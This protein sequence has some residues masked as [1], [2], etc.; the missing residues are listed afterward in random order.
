MTG[1]HISN[2]QLNLDVNNADG[3]VDGQEIPAQLTPFDPDST[4]WKEVREETYTYYNPNPNAPKVVAPD[5]EDVD[6]S[7][8]L[9]DDDYCAD[10]DN[11]QNEEQKEANPSV[12]E[13]RQHYEDNCLHTERIRLAKQTQQLYNKKV[14]PYTENQRCYKKRM[15]S[16]HFEVH[17]PTPTITRS[18][19][20]RNLNYALQV[21]RSNAL[22]KR[23]QNG[24]V[25]VDGSNIRL[26]MQ[27][28][29]KRDAIMDHLHQ[30][31]KSKT[32]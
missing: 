29:N 9:N 5:N 15:I 3:S 20:L 26:Y 2:E 25:S 11:A 19:E 16:E 32:S 1:V 30:N 27:I 21:M 13:Y 28:M 8:V 22:Y 6:E 31:K 18:I 17:A 7:E 10:C 23:D 14:R 12:E 4:N 24:V